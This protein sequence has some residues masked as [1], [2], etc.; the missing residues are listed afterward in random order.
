MEV[1]RQ[2]FL[3]SDFYRK[4]TFLKKI[5]LSFPHLDWDADFCRCTQKSAFKLSAS[6]TYTFGGTAILAVSFH[7]LE[8]CAT[9]LCYYNSVF[10]IAWPGE[11]CKQEYEGCQLLL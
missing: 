5:D 4:E 7:R 1:R 2:P 6:F 11:K 3:H 8:T 10:A 9:N